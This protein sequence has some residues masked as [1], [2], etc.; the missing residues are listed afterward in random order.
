M[1][2]P[3]KKSVPCSPLTSKSTRICLELFW[4]V[5]ACIR[6]C[7]MFDQCLFLS[8]FIWDYFFTCVIMDSFSW[9]QWF[10][11]KNI[12]MMDLYLTNTQLLVS[13][14]INVIFIF[15][16][17]IPLRRK[18][19]YNSYF[20]VTHWWIAKPFSLIWLSI[21][22]LTSA[23]FVFLITYTVVHNGVQQNSIKNIT[24]W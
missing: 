13:Q 9:K 20:E 2:S 11:V 17:T 22:T 12:A 10:E 6:I 21:L 1:L 4:T 16:L 8:W 15:G 18:K 5:L 23:V 3:V 24:F 19:Y 7:T 14:N